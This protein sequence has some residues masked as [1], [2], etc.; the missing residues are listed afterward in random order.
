MNKTAMR[1]YYVYFGEHMNVF[2][3]D[4]CLELSGHLILFIQQMC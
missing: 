4:L 3:L 2:L 1:L